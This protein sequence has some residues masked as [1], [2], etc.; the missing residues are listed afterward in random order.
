MS[1]LKKPYRE[2]ADE[3]DDE[4]GEKRVKNSIG[5][6]LEQGGAEL[7]AHTEPHEQDAYV[8]ERRENPPDKRD[9]RE[10]VA[11]TDSIEHKRSDDDR[12]PAYRRGKIDVGLQD[13][14]RIKC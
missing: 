6:F 11:R 5:E 7:C 13:M 2:L 8:L 3:D 1:L 14:H 10:E 9:E 12:N 4:C